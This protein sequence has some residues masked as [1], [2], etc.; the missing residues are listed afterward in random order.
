MSMANSLEVR[1]PFFDHE[2]IEYVMRIPDKFK[3][4]SV[5]KSLL[6]NSVNNLIPAEIY[7]RPKKGFVFPW[8]NWLR[9]ELKTYCEIR[10][11]TLSQRDFVN[12][13][14]VI[15]YWMISSSTGMP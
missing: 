8:N 11:Q 9:N 12:Q 13:Q 7:E 10:L 3:K 6:I 2:L 15:K 14:A 5:P 4:G 1:E